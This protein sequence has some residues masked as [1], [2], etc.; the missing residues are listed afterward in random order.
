ML[1][2]LCGWSCFAQE[3]KSPAPKKNAC[4]IVSKAEAEAV[5]GA[6]LNAAE[7]TRKGTVCRYLEPGYDAAPAGKK[8]VTIDVFESDF[9]NASD[10]NQRLDAIDDERSQSKTTMAARELP[11]F[12]DD[13]IWVWSG[14]DFGA[15]YAFKGGTVEV[16][17][18]ISGISEEAALAAAKKFATRALKGTGKTGF[19]YN[20]PDVDLRRDAYN[21]A[22]MLKLLYGEAFSRI[23]DDALTRAY[24]VSLVQGFGGVC[25][26]IAEMDAVLDYGFYS[27]RRA[28]RG[29]A[30]ADESDKAFAEMMEALRGSAPEVVRA[31]NEDAATF[32]K[33][34]MEKKGCSSHPMQ[35][36]Y[37]EIAELAMER[38]GLPP[39][40]DDDA[41]FLGM[42]S[43]AME[44]KYKGGFEGRTS[45]AEQ[46]QLQ[47]VKEGC[48]ASGKDVVVT[49]SKE[50]FCRCQVEAAKESKLGPGELELL[51]G[52]FSQATL[53]QVGAKNAGYLRREQACFR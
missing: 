6:K 37:N 18:R 25:P 34:N 7:V 40:V 12:A 31:G 36:I 35:H 5:V 2:G 1:L 14:G 27:A 13:A 16:G 8:H 32:F 19:L 48:V 33:L 23:P 42:M 47:R 38:R 11:E 21:G 52:R 22:Q 50:G 9:P 41:G 20:P 51:E 10:V 30:N 53:T 46:G 28:N 49:G 15:L 39:D 26:K 43:P 29:A 17:I 44:E 45:A 4:A 3:K 24:V